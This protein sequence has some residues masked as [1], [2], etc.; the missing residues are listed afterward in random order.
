M[1]LH[2]WS[3]VESGIFHDFQTAWIAEIRN[4]L[5]A[6][7]LPGDY[8]ALAEQ[9]AGG[10]IADILALHTPPRPED[11]QPPTPPPIGSGGGT[12]VA[13]APPRAHLEESIELAIK[14]LRRSLSIRHVRTHKI[15]AL[16]EIV[17]PAN[18]DR[19]AH[20]EEFSVKTAD[21]L[22]RGINVLV[23]DL[24]ATGKHDPMGVHY[25]IR[26]RIAPLADPPQR[27]S[28]RS[29]LASYRVD[30]RRI[31]MYVE[32]PQL[33]HPQLEHPQQDA[34]LPEMPIFLNAEYYVN[35][36]L[37]ATYIEAWHGMPAFWKKVIL[38]EIE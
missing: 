22:G 33:E 14:D 13:E 32:H 17:S 7:L 6:G 18:K 15:V 35:V 12:A 21:A 20:L 9:H 16:L 11:L 2:D 10:F 19:P 25:S 24:F 38:G 5:N 23:V 8:Y 34:Q 31:V 4:A 26:D 27:A 28:P 36:P 1:P 30:G 29:T 3:R 37:E